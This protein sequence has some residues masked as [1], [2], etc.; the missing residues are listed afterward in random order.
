ESAPTSVATPP[1]Q[2]SS[3]SQDPVP[4]NLIFSAPAAQTAKTELSAANTKMRNISLPVPPRSPNLIVGVATSKDGKL[5]EGA[6]VQ[7]LDPTGLPARA[8]K[9]N[10]LGQFATSTPL[11]PG[12]YRI[13]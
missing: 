11:A 5:V 4:T 8:M 6:I 13:E 2:S 1:T 12:T 10:A 9:T 3:Q 7:V